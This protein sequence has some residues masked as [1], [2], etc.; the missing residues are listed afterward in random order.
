VVSGAVSFGVVSCGASFLLH[1]VIKKTDSNRMMANKK[2]SFFITVSPFV[3]K[4]RETLPL[5]YTLVFQIAI[6]RRKK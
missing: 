4:I 1:A 2:L 3:G 6:E 5:L